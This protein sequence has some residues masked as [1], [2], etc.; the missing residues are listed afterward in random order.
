VPSVLW[1]GFA[2]RQA[3]LVA[4]L[5][6]G[7]VSEAGAGAGETQ[8]IRM[9]LA[10]PPRNL[11]PRLATDAT[12]S[13]VNALLYRQLTRFDAQSRPVPDLAT[14]EQ[15]GPTRYR[16]TLGGE[17]RDFSTGQ[18]LT[19]SDVKATY[20][21]ALD[22][23]MASP[24]RASLENISEILVEGPD[25]LEFHLRQADPLFPGY[26]GL[27]LVPAE[28]IEAGHP[29]AQQP[30]GSGPFRLL[31]WPQPGRLVLER[32]RDG[33]V[34][35]LLTVKDANVRVM[36]LLR[37][38]IDLLQNDLAPELVG[39]LRG[40]DQVRLETA[41]GSNFS[42][43]G[44]SLADPVTGLPQ[45]RQALALAIDRQEILTYLYQGRGRLATGLF[46]PEHWAAGGEGAEPVHDP[47]RAR[48]L[49]AELGYG[50]DRPLQ[51]SYKTSS[52]PL[53][54][55]FATIIQAQV[56]RVGIELRIQS[57]DWGTFF[58]DIRAGRFQLYG[59]TWVGIRSP[60]I[61]RYVFHSR[62]VPP[63]GAN[64]GRYANPEVDRL[65]EV[66]HGEPDLERQAAL[67]QRI[68]TILLQDLP[69]I[70]L[71]YE[72]QF[73]AARP[74]IRGYRLAGD[75]NYDAL[76]RVGRWVAAQP[77]PGAP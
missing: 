45:V 9:G 23:T 65:I 41:P 54:I 29:F 31:S 68:Q 4:L 15:L 47:T 40:H 50:M 70:P 69:Y 2:W 60:D 74:E 21:S 37:G 30:V 14:W 19:S 38:E 53:R 72:D 56:A 32:R 18:R 12:S 55:R 33:Q 43:L 3:I 1:P 26:L 13:R 73:Y 71:W 44:F 77:E 57:Y 51:L 49:L 16:F 8:P 48:A 27:G 61:F 34:I 58:D 66:A 22:P 10:G 59:L 17:G 28:L 67:Y 5:V 46:P 25:R 62:S 52:D 24:H 39:F 42:Y 35:E 11:D 75:G 7:L 63:E 76:A 6:L 36:K 20:E 64:R